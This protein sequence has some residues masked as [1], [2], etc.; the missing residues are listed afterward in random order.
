MSKRERGGQ[1][2]RKK[3][4]EREKERETERVTDRHRE[5]ETENSFMIS[6]PAQF[7]RTSNLPSTPAFI[8]SAP[9]FF[10]ANHHSFSPSLFSSLLL[11]F[12]FFS[13][14]LFIQIQHTSTIS[15]HQQFAIDTSFYSI[16]T[17]VFLRTPPQFQ[18]STITERDN[19]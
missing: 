12:L 4:R 1:K 15:A 19:S 17:S 11:P 2:E 14:P 13:H 7:P 3:E 8:P 9:V 6:T 5:R 16:G 10:S 18:R